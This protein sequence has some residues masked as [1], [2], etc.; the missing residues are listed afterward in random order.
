MEKNNHSLEELGGFYSLFLVRQSV[1]RTCRAYPLIGES[2]QRVLEAILG[3]CKKHNELQEAY[4]KVVGFRKGVVT[5]ELSGRLGDAM[6]ANEKQ[7]YNE[8]LFA[9]RFAGKEK[10]RDFFNSWRE[11]DF[12]LHKAILGERNWIT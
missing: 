1:L 11:I 8:L 2:R 3:F 7:A 5:D 6:F 10:A 12:E 9:A 4:S